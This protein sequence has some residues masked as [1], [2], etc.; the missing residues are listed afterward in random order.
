MQ[1]LAQN[2]VKKFQYIFK[3]FHPNNQIFLG[4]F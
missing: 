2:I 4:I 1:I 3:Y